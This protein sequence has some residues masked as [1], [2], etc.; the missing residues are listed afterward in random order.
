MPI[1]WD[2]VCPR[3]RE[4]GEGA[5]GKRCTVWVFKDEAEF[6]RLAKRYKQRER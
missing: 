2:Q 1:I 5:A 4:E 3:E 6:R